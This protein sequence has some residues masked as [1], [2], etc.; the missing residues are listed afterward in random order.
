MAYEK[1]DKTLLKRSRNIR[2]GVL[3]IILLLLTGAGIWH[4]VGG[5]IRPA[6]VD[7]LCPFGGIEAAYANYSGNHVSFSFIDFHSDY[8]RNYIHRRFFLDHPVS[9]DLGRK[10]GCF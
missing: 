6:S 4:Q 3:T 5:A 2:L 10:I 1:A 9:E 7:A 8:R